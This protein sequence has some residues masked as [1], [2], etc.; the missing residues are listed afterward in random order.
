MQAEREGLGLFALLLSLLAFRV[1]SSPLV[2]RTEREGEPQREGALVAFIG[3]IENRL[4]FREKLRVPLPGLA[5]S[6]GKRD[7]RGREG[8]R[9]CVC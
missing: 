6:I 9:K 3:I 5:E 1:S 4:R 2:H 8:E 7:P